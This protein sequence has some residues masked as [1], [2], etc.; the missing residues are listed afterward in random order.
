M[1]EDS[2]QPFGFWDSR[3]DKLNDDRRLVSPSDVS[4]ALAVALANGDKSN[5]I[6]KVKKE[7]DH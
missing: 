1:E 2:Y 7:T 4:D 5:K 3:H 6:M